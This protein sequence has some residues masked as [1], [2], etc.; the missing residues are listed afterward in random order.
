[1]ADNLN[2]ETERAVIAKKTLSILDSHSIV[3]I[4]GLADEEARSL[5]G[6]DAMLVSS[7]IAD[8]LTELYKPPSGQQLDFG[9][10]SYFVSV[11]RDDYLSGTLTPLN[12]NAFQATLAHI[13]FRS[14]GVA[15]VFL[16]TQKWTDDQKSEFLDSV[17]TVCE[18]LNN[19]LRDC[20]RAHSYMAV[21]L[22][23]KPDPEI[24]KPNEAL[25]EAFCGKPRDQEVGA[26]VLKKLPFAAKVELR[27]IIFKNAKKAFS[28]LKSKQILREIVGGEQYSHKDSTD[29]LRRYLESSQLNECG[30]SK[31]LVSVENWNAA[32]NFVCLAI[33]AIALRE[34]KGLESPENLSEVEYMPSV[35]EASA[36]IGQRMRLLHPDNAFLINKL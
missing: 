26:S 29:A 2:S 12:W 33:E 15:E 3:A 20:H 6:L 32:A 18:H 11:D 35:E 8:V 17:Q 13:S 5:M 19:R 34:G 16:S 9:D 36:M 21:A 10:S 14:K 22:S 28:V 4:K 27:T 7:I 31:R 23:P 25:R 24:H 1:M 30:E